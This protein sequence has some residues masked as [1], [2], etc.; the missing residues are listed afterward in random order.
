MKTN[1]FNRKY[2]I[3]DDVTIQLK[4]NNKNH[5]KKS[6]FEMIEGKFKLLATY[7]G[8][9]IENVTLYLPEYASQ[10]YSYESAMIDNDVDYV[11]CILS[12]NDLRH[13]LN[14]KTKHIELF[15]NGFLITNHYIDIHPAYFFDKSVGFLFNLK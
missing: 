10:M 15:D 12:S 3:I 5:S 7:D 13:P 9:K 4:S 8:K 1:I 2:E 11:K 6:Q 14:E